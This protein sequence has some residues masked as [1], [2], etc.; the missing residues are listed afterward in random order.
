M[1]FSLGLVLIVVALWMASGQSIISAPRW[2]HSAAL[3]DTR[4]YVVGGRSGINGSTSPLASDNFVASI[5]ISQSFNTNSPRWVFVSTS[6]DQPNLMT[7]G[8]MAVDANRKRLIL[9]GGELDGHDSP[10]DAVW[11]LD[12]AQ[13][14][15]KLESRKGA[16]EPRRVSAAV[17]LDEAHIYVYGG[18]D[19]KDKN[20]QKKFDD[21]Y[22]L[23]K[24]SL[25]WSKCKKA[26]GTNSALFRHTLSYVPGRN[27]LLSIGGA[28]D[29]SL[30]SMD[31]LSWYNPEK[32]EWGQ[33]RPTATPLFRGANTALWSLASASSSLAAAISVAT[34][35]QRC[36]GVGYDHVYMVKASG[37]ERARR[38]VRALGYYGH[39]HLRP[40]SPDTV[41][42]RTVRQLR[43]QI[44]R[45]QMGLMPT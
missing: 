17:A 25:S 38:T 12:L 14:T 4:L 40:G 19:G 45:H 27:I 8:T 9:F 11:T 28:S 39:G 16:P 3:I 7:N 43:N 26:A 2:G 10:S 23:S 18:I 6:G 24:S 44:L 20:Q 21:L 35:L 37:E 34:L 13:R 33:T 30:A 41:F 29:D 22:K 32:D 5:D 15:W 36:G 31:K 42:L 1:R